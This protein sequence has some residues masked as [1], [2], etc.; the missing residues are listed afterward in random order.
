M[1][2]YVNIST[3]TIYNYPKSNFNHVDIVVDIEIFNGINQFNLILRT[4]TP[5][6]EPLHNKCQNF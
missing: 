3:K 5:S 4:V 1:L 2:R 6:H